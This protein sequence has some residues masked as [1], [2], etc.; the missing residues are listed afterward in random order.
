LGEDGCMKKP[1][2]VSDNVST[3]SKDQNREAE[4]GLEPNLAPQT[5]AEKKVVTCF[6]A[7]MAAEREFGPGIE[8][9]R[10]MIELRT[11]IKASGD[12]IPA[13]HWAAGRQTEA[14]QS[15]KRAQSLRRP[16]L[17]DPGHDL[18][19]PLDGVRDRADGRWN[20]LPALVLRQLPGRKDRCGDQRKIARP[21]ASGE[22]R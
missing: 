21:Y 4:I 13:H 19:G 9:G 12:R 1:K 17:I 22:E 18:F 8:F 2:T 3:I 15:T 20:S 14:L 5:D 7:L 16:P 11:E 6:A 10:A